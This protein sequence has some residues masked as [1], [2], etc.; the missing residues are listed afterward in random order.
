MSLQNPAF[1][2][3]IRNDSAR[4]TG[5]RQSPYRGVGCPHNNPFFLQGRRRR[6]EKADLHKK[7]LLCRVAKISIPNVPLLRTTTIAIDSL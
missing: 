1:F 7:K 3:Q 6:P 4:G 5:G 2:L